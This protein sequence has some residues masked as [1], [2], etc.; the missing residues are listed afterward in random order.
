[1]HGRPGGRTRRGSAST[2]PTTATEGHAI[3]IAW[4]EQVRILGRQRR[5]HLSQRTD[6]VDYP[7]A[8]AMR[9]GNEVALLDREVMHGHRWQVELQPLP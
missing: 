6:V 5:R 3:R 2:T 4:L 7:E 1:M 9:G 8:A